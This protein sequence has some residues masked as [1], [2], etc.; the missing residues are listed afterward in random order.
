MKK[1]NSFKKVIFWII[2]AIIGFQ[3]LENMIEKKLNSIWDGSYNYDEA[4][5]NMISSSEN[6]ILDNELKAF[7]R[8]N[9]I[10]LNIV[11]ADTLDIMS[12]LNIEKYRYQY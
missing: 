12:K 5:F 11:Y 8:R 7:A 10:S 1:N 2:I 6:E 3:L 9:D 4:K